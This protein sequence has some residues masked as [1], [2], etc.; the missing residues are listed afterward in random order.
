MCVV[1]QVGSHHNFAAALAC[2][3]TDQLSEQKALPKRG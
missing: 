2:T 1:S 3:L